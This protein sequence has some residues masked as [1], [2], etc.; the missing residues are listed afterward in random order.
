MKPAVGLFTKPV[1]PGRVKTRLSPPLSPQ[2]CAALYSAFLVDIS[3]MLAS[4][5]DWD[6]IV[7]S[8][9]PDRQR[10]AWP[11]EAPEPKGWRRQQGENLGERIQ[12][13]LDEL[14]D[15]D[16]GAAVILGSDHPT[17][18]REMM[19]Q[20]FDSFGE[21]DVVFGPSLD[22]GYYLVGTTR[23]RTGIFSDVPWSTPEVLERT[24]ENVRAAGLT[25]AFLP[26]WY[27]VDTP[28]DLRFLRT[29]LRALEL[30]S[31]EGAICPR[32]REVLETIPGTDS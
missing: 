14:L 32:T 25:P 20:A 16:R 11:A 29:H 27:D 9:E 12:S 10:T 30:A 17:V 2:D 7:Y 15:E 6:W 19:A 18:S 31:P 26:P 8:T 13:A 3:T 21:A 22:G 4:G 1:V 24:L 28:D 23:P 5:P